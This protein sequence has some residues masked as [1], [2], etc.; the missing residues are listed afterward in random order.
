ML[1]CACICLYVH[2]FFFLFCPRRKREK[3]AQ[4][5]TWCPAMCCQKGNQMS[6]KRLRRFRDSNTRLQGDMCQYLP[7][8][9]RWLWHLVKFWDFYIFSQ[10]HT[11]SDNTYIYIHI[12]SIHAIHAHTDTYMHA[13]RPVPSYSGSFVASWD[14]QRLPQPPKDPSPPWLA[15]ACIWLYV[16]CM[17]CMYCMYMYVLS[18]CEC[19]WLDI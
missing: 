3:V 10:I 1:V 7:L 9:Q 8:S 11:H 6:A 17:Y 13:P 4:A 12:H 5:R 14:I 2:V 16:Y 15:H 18:E 19:I